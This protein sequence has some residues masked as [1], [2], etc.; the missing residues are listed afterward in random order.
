M[1]RYITP[2]LFTKNAGLMAG[3]LICMNYSEFILFHIFYYS[4]ISV[5]LNFL[6]RIK[7]RMLFYTA[8]VYSYIINRISDITFIH[9]SYYAVFKKLNFVF[10]IIYSRTVLSSE[11][12]ILTALTGSLVIL[13]CPIILF[14]VS[15][16]SN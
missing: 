8:K 2:L 9:F 5:I 6:L 15:R 7:F 1:L 3:I 14:M 13:T 12:S 16:I 10:Y 4:E 11:S